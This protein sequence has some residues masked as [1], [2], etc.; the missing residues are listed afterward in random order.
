MATLQ[1]EK[2]ERDMLIKLLAELTSINPS[3]LVRREQ[4]GNELSFETA[5]PIFIRTLNLFKELNNINLE[6]IPLNQLNSIKSQVSDAIEKFKSIKTFTSNQ[7]NPVNVRDQLVANLQEK[8]SSYFATL[9][10]ILAYA[11]KKETDLTKLENDGKEILKSMNESKDYFVTQ[12]KNVTEEMTSILEKVRQ[13]AAE[14]GV[15][16]HATHFETEAKY[17]LTQSFRWMIAT[18]TFAFLTIA[19]GIASFFLFPHTTEINGVLPAIISKLIILVGLY[20]GLVWSAKNYRSNRHNFVVNTHRQNSLKTFETFV[21]A[22]GNDIET[23]NAVLLQATKT[24]FGYQ[25]SGYVVNESDSDNSPN[26]FE[27]IKNFYKS[28]V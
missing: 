20:Y 26:Y 16:Q 17:H 19:W 22:A 6:I 25:P 13:A 18:G 10:T 1:E 14:V 8:Y 12:Q 2:N 11:H 24:I 3:E 4:L 21:K 15:A 23:K 28:N 7:S 27:I 9:H 5:L